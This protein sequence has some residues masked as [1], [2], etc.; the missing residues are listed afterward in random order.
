[1]MIKEMESEIRS[2]SGTLV[3]RVLRLSYGAQSE[4]QAQMDF[5]HRVYSGHSD[6]RIHAL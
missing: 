6:Y 4:A 3:G 1:M 2:R 5:L